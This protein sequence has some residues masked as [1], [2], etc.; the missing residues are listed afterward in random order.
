MRLVNEFQRI[1][2]EVPQTIIDIGDEHVLND[3]LGNIKLA[4]KIQ[5]NSKKK[6]VKE[7]EAAV[8]L[9]ELPEKYVVLDETNPAVPRVI[10]FVWYKIQNLN[11]INRKAASQI[12]VWRAGGYPI[13]TGLAEYVF[14]ELIL[15]I[16]GTIVTDYQQTNNGKRFWQDR[17][18]KAL[19]AK[20]YV[21]Y[22]NFQPERVIKQINHISDLEDLDKQAYGVHQKF[23]QRRLIIAEDPIVLT[24]S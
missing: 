7:L 13:L 17:I 15:P 12:L 19:K 6:V 11:F 22:V 5:A 3:K 8:T 10:Y 2:L 1:L 4:R 18:G 14:N 21:Y 9:Y 23:R 20:K 24:N 16:T